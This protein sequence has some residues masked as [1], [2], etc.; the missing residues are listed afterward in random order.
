MR[1]KFSKRVF[2]PQTLIEITTELAQDL[3]TLPSTFTSGRICLLV[4]AFC[5]RS[6]RLTA[7]VIASG[8]TPTCG[9]KRHDNERRGCTHG[10]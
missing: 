1:Q 6:L 9:G 4:N 3:P 5:W 10:L 8:C 7:A 2:T